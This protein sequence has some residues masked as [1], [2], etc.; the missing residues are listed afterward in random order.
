MFARRCLSRCGLLGHLHATDAAPSW[1]M[2]TEVSFWQGTQGQNMR[3]CNELQ[4]T[5]LRCLLLMLLEPKS[6]FSHLS[7]L[8]RRELNLVCSPVNWRRF[9]YT[10]PF[11]SGEQTWKRSRR[12][13]DCRWIDQ[14][15]W[16][17]SKLASYWASP[18]EKK[19]DLKME[20]PQSAEPLSRSRST[21][22][23]TTWLQ[24]KSK[25]RKRNEWNQ[26]HKMLQILKLQFSNRSLFHLHA[27][28][29]KITSQEINCRELLKH[30][31]LKK[32]HNNCL[33]ESRGF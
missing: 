17:Q 16:H 24:N 22:T 20:Y 4:R 18:N 31:E 13:S 7:R 6:C 15:G 1:K 12:C 21:G 19:H 27:Y 11:P 29:E 8:L 2:C 30:T 25:T 23:L 3:R 10:S 9:V 28:V 5:F 33:P 26:D 32:P 14:T